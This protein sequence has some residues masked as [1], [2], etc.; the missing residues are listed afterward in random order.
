MRFAPQ[1]QLDDDE[2][3]LGCEGKTPSGHLKLK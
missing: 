1:Y 2:E 3:L